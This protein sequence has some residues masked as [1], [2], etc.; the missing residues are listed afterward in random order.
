MKFPGMRT[1]SAAVLASIQA[2]FPSVRDYQA[3]LVDDVVDGIRSAV[4]RPVPRELRARF[5][6][7]G[8]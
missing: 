6:I 1:V 2:V 5:S 8:R 3:T 7:A 4:A